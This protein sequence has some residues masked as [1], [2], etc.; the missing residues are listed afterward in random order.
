MNIP[1]GWSL[2]RLDEVCPLQRGFDLPTAQIKEGDY[3]VVYSN[4]VI[5]YHHLHKV[6]SPGVVTGRSGTIGKVTYV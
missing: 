2:K 6:R 5:N 3:P 1:K 4:G